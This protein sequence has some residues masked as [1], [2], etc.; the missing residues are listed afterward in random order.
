MKMRTSF[1][2]TKNITPKDR[3]VI[4]QTHGLIILKNRRYLTNEMNITYEKDCFVVLMTQMRIEMRFRGEGL[5]A[6]LTQPMILS[7]TGLVQFLLVKTISTSVEDA[8]RRDGQLIAFIDRN[9]ALLEEMNRTFSVEQRRYLC[10]IVADQSTV[11][12]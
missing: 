12:T 1:R 5:I 11:F 2:S 8:L 7:Q 10:E 6:I 3:T 4:S 9:H